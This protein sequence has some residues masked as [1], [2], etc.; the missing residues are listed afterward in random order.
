MR[1][2]SQFARAIDAGLTELL[3][4]VRVDGGQPPSRKLGRSPLNPAPEVG[5]TGFVDSLFRF[6][7]ETLARQ[8]PSR[9]QVAG[10]ANMLEATNVDDE[11]ELEVT[12]VVARR[13]LLPNGRETL[14]LGVL[15]TCLLP[16]RTGIRVP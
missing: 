6:Y 12:T 15:V 9:Q 4:V 7:G 11:E 3:H 16:V 8:L 1:G 5:H 14:A 13:P 2:P 10:G